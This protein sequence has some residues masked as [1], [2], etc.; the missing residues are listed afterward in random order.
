MIPIG[1]DPDRIRALGRRTS[2][3]I[4]ALDGI[5]S[6]DPAAAEAMR[7]VRLLRRN[8][9]DHWMPLIREIESSRSMT[10][11]TS[12]PVHRL[13]ATWLHPEVWLRHRCHDADDHL[14]DSPQG[15][16]DDVVDEAFRAVLSRLD[17]D[18]VLTR[19][20]EMSR[21]AAIAGIPVDPS[22]PRWRGMLAALADDLADRLRGDADGGF[23]A[24]IVSAATKTPLIALAAPFSPRLGVLAA[25]LARAM[26]RVERWAPDLHPHTYERAVDAVLELLLD[27]PSACLDLLLDERALRSLAGWP[28][29]DA[30]VV[31]GVVRNGLETAVRTE[32]TRLLDGYAVLGSLV[33]LANGP[34][35]GGFAPGASRG[36]AESLAVYIDT[37][38]PAVRYEHSEAVTV[39]LFDPDA[40]VRLGTYDEVVDLF[41]AVLRDEA[42]QAAVGVTIAAYTDQIVEDL[43]EHVADH[44]GIEYVAR[45][46]DLVADAVRTEQAEVV[47]VAAQSLARRRRVGTIVTLGVGVGLGPASTLAGHVVRTTARAVVEEGTGITRSTRDR[48]VDLSIAATVHRHVGVAVL[49][50]LSTTEALRTGDHL[51]DVTDEQWELVREHLDDIE[52]A[53]DDIAE[54]SER[55]DR[56]ERYIEQFI[57]PLGAHLRSVRAAPNVGELEEDRSSRPDDDR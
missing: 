28:S 24:A 3:S 17:D 39:H 49:E 4:R 14:P 47:L 8:L 16:T 15:W 2:D 57:P 56:M 32:P 38:A 55:V 42:A 6:S 46:A 43:G 7:V 21:S 35:D 23:G 13:R 26:L 11:W 50:R 37:L 40:T 34:L 45:F 1:F 41:G 18:E 12:H 48:V 27:D 52:R 44:V 31:H 30:D 22:D 10:D 25:E 19:L 33:E 9:A 36:V 51:D 53:G 29:L 54:R 20:E 5:R